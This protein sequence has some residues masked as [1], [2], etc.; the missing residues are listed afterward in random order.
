[1]TAVSTSTIPTPV[2]VVV[3]G[4]GIAGASAA[5]ALAERASV[6]LVEQA[7]TA[8]YHATG[9]SASVLS[10]TSGHSLVCALA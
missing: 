2:D 10:E 1:M 9:R 6:V 5:W 8:G 3:I 7:P 4:G